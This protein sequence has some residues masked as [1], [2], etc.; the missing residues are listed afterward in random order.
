MLL[1]LLIYFFWITFKLYILKIKKKKK[2]WSTRHTTCDCYSISSSRSTSVALETQ[3]GSKCTCPAV[4]YLSF[5][6][7]NDNSTTISPVD[8]G[9]K[10]NVHKTFNLRPMSTKIMSEYCITLTTWKFHP[11]ALNFGGWS[12]SMTVTSYFRSKS[13][14]S[15]ERGYRKPIDRRLK[16]LPN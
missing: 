15:K 5:Q 3:T 2:N 10:L 8:T 13:D 4:L 6:F 11:L 16:T 1:N 7:R 14:H 9:R 12:F